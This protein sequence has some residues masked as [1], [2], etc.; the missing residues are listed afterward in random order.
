MSNAGM[1]KLLTDKA[2]FEAELAGQHEAM[3]TANAALRD[4][5]AAAT[6]RVDA[7]NT[8]HQLECSR[9]TREITQLKELQK[10]DLLLKRSTSTDDA[11]PAELGGG[12]AEAEDIAVGAPTAGSVDSAVDTRAEV[13][14]ADGVGSATTQINVHHTDDTRGPQPS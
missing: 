13:S 6:R 7:A 5:V 14:S 10:A 8:N 12:D 3:Q 1:R 4:T 9:L 11:A 2:V